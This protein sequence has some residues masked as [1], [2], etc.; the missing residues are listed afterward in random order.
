MR[1]CSKAGRCHQSQPGENAHEFL[2]VWLS[3]LSLRQELRQCPEHFVNLVGAVAV[4]E[5]DAGLAGQVLHDLGPAVLFSGAEL[6]LDPPAVVPR[7]DVDGPVTGVLRLGHVV[8]DPV[9]PSVSSEAV[10][11]ESL[12]DP[13]DLSLGVENGPATSDVLHGRQVHCGE[14]PELV[15][16]GGQPLEPPR[17][18]EAEE[19]DIEALGGQA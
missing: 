3:G 12:Y 17:D 7:V 13:L 16:D 18:V 9:G 11:T 5:V 15:L 19:V 6:H 14:P 2:R 8:S 1:P 4:L 10:G